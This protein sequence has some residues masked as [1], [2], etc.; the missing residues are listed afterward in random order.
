[1]KHEGLGG[2]CAQASE[3]FLNASLQPHKD[4]TH[5]EGSPPFFTEYTRKK[6]VE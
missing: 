3:G 4:K 1:M 6:K 2:K 5:L